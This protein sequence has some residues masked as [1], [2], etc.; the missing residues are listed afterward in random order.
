MWTTAAERLKAFVR[1][2]LRRVLASNLANSYAHV[3]HVGLQYSEAIVALG[4]LRHF[5]E[6]QRASPICSQWYPAADA[7]GVRRRVLHRLEPDAQCPLSPLVGGTPH[8]LPISETLAQPA[9]LQAAF[10]VESILVPILYQL[11]PGGLSADF[12]RL[13]QRRLAQAVFVP[14]LAV[15][16]ELRTPVGAF[17]IPCVRGHPMA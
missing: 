14:R 8:P 1:Y 4:F 15:F 12:T 10:A 6:G 2:A 16:A 11:L 7:K 13:S 9:G 5:L 17:G 3:V